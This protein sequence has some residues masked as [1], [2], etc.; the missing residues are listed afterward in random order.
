MGDKAQ[1]ALEGSQDLYAD[2]QKR[3]EN[4][5]KNEFIMGIV[6]I[7]TST[8]TMGLSSIVERNKSQQ[9]T[10]QTMQDSREETQQKE[11]REKLEKVK[12]DT[13]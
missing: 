11:S 5:E 3:E 2:A 4:A 7:C 6:N 12:A 10:Q 9:E 8:L 13:L 1:E